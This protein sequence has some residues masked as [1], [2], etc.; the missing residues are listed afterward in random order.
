MALLAAGKALKDT[1]PK[2]INKDDTGV[3]MA[4]GFGALQTTFDFL[5]SY[6]EKGDKL[7]SPTHFSNS[8]HNAAAAHISICYGITGPNLTVSQFD[9]SF[10]SALMTAETWL[11]TGSSKA[12][13]VGVSDAFCD[14]LGYCIKK[15]LSI[16]NVSGYS[17]GESAVFFLLTGNQETS[18]YG[19]F[20]QITIGNYLKDGLNI[21]ED[22]PL[23]LSPS[24]ID[25]CNDNFMQFLK[26]NNGIVYQN[27]L[28]SPTDC[29]IGSF[30]SIG[31]K[32]KICYIK[33]GQYGEYGQMLINPIVQ[34]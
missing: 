11:A 32:Q 4:T 27:Q 34:K 20:D 31:L 6:I 29:G 8:V 24:A 18:K 1:D 25:T 15:F 26:K 28:F 30:Y 33:I 13:L 2:L 16:N 22:I 12:V 17:F 21:T 5:D 9:M 7:A 3:I 10:V 14:I 23:V 19:A